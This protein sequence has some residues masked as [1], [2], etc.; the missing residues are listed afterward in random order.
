MLKQKGDL[1][2]GK[3]SYWAKKHLRPGCNEGLMRLLAV[4]KEGGGKREYSRRRTKRIGKIGER[5]GERERD[6][7]GKRGEK[8]G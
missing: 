1:S 3:K 6:K 8:G 7:R 2:G 4:R 5:R